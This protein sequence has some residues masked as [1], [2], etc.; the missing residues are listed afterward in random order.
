MFARAFGWRSRSAGRVAIALMAEGIVQPSL[1]CVE[2]GEMADSHA[3]GWKVFLTADEP[4]E[5]PAYCPECAE[6]SSVS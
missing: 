5:T 1:V 4:P 3:Q 6:R 2:C